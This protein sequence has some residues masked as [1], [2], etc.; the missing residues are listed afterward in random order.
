MS[1]GQ[2]HNTFTFLPFSFIFEKM[3]MIFLQV[4]FFKNKVACEAPAQHELAS[5]WRLLFGECADF[6]CPR[7]ARS[8]E[9]QLATI[10]HPT[11]HQVY[12]RQADNTSM[13]PQEKEQISHTKSGSP[14]NFLPCLK[15]LLFCGSQAISFLKLH[16]PANV[17]MLFIFES[18]CMNRVNSTVTSYIWMHSKMIKF[19][20]SSR[21]HSKL[22]I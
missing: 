9:W 13:F 3:K 4:L 11:C 22:K 6:S 10:C 7:G 15:L 5:W 2:L 19:Q 14:H 21:L 18:F 16:F 1:K 8:W 20:L 12:T 17:N